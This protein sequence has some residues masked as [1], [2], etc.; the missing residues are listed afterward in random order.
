MG[1]A[2]GVFLEVEVIHRAG[3]GAVG[4]ARQ[5]AR[6]G[7]AQVARVFRLAQAAPGGVL[8]VLEDLGQ[9]ARVGQLLPGLHLHHVRGDGGDEGRVRRRGDLGHFAQG[10]HV[11]GAVIEVEVAHQAAEWL[12]AELAV[13]FFVDLLEDRALVEAHALVAFQ[14]AAE[15]LLGQRHEADLQHLVG[16]GVVHQIVQAAPG[17]FQFLEFG[18][19]DDQVDL[20]GQLAVDLGDDRL[21]RAVGIARH[22][23]CILQG[24]LGQR[25]DG[26]FHRLA[27]L[28]GLGLEFLVQQRGERV[29]VQGLFAGAG[30]LH[31]I[32]HVHHCSPLGVGS[33]Q[34]RFQACSKPPGT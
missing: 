4:Q 27:G 12:A 14:L 21:D 34:R 28:F 9:V 19:V 13:L 5:E 2:G 30:R 16:F 17:A 31:L 25:L 8:G 32:G 15:L 3:G 23:H 10:F 18:M 11:L 22:H 24:L 1:T 26:M 7:Q 33:I 6:H 29:P 20:L